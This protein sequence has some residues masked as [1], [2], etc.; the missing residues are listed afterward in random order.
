MR[1]LGRNMKKML[2]ILMA[3]AAA[4]AMG[5]DA[6]AAEDCLT[7]HGRKGAVRFV[8]EGLYGA[9]VHGKLPC[10]SCHLAVG[11]FPHGKV[12]QV[13]CFICHFT[14]NMGA[15]KV[16]EFKES[17]HGKALAKGN[18][19]A[20]NCQT[21]HGS[22]SIFAARDERSMT[23]RQNVALLCSGCH[24]AEYQEYQQSIHGQEFLEK[25][26]QGAAVCM[27]CHMEHHL[28]RGVDEPAW[29]LNL[30]NECGG[31]H[32]EQLDTYRKTFH[33]K[34]ARLGYVTVAKCS[35]CHGSHKILSAKSMDSMISEGHIVATCGKCHP[36][37][38]AAF[39]RFYA[40]PEEGNR[41]KYPMLFYVYF[42]MTSLLIGVFTFFFIHTSL[43]AYRA[44]KVRMR[45]E[46]G[47][48]E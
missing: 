11:G 5:N 24:R 43:W 31:C 42:F 34:V 17:I 19:S 29:K 18:M 1:S 27:D 23:S 30:I 39:T 32:A 10:N 33:G 48:D 20:P 37:A 36:G 21:C 46:D 15:P 45:G 13:K 2:L 7:C 44:L 16:K 14:G 9:S 8:D 22:H 28:I 26:N 35:D 38:T 40:H 3:L 25:R 6:S 47:G 12:A 41:K 4:L